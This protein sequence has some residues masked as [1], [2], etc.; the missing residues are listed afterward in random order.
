MKGNSYDTRFLAELYYS[1]EQNRQ[2]KI[3][4]ILQ[5]SK[6]NYLS[7]IA[8]GEIYQIILKKE[9]RTVGDLR[10]QALR[11]DFELIDATGEVTL[12]AALI[13]HHREMPHADSLIAATA[14]LLDVPC[15]SDDPHFHLVENLKV[16]WID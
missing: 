4:E 12:E 14:R 15:Y 10:V 2:K 8:L 9:G 16:K 11:R 5:T 13:R 3:K 6:P 1:Q 7:S